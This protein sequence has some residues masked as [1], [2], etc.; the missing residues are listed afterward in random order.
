M[1]L[2]QKMWRER[3]NIGLKIEP[4]LVAVLAFLEPAK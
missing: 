1:I 4:A 3:P 2:A